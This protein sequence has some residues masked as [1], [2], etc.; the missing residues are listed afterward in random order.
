MRVVWSSHPMVQNGMSAY[1]HAIILSGTRV[2]TRLV[3]HTRAASNAVSNLEHTRA[4][5]CPADCFCF[6]LLAAALGFYS[7]NLFLVSDL[8]TVSHKHM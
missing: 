4:W 8:S 5:V 7:P 3:R 2:D 6:E 1:Q